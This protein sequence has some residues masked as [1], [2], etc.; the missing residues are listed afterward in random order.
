VA[1]KLASAP[2]RPAASAARPPAS[3]APAPAT[4]A[5]RASGDDPG[6]G[7]KAASSPD[8]SGLKEAF[9]SAIQQQRP[10]V[11]G[12]NVAQAQRIDVVGD[13]I[14]FR[15]GPVQTLLGDQVSQLK[16]WLEGLASEIAGRRITVAADVAKGEAGA[17][18][19]RAS[20]KPAAEPARD[21]KAEAM[22]D[23]VL[24]SLLD[25]IP[26]EVKDITELKKP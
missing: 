22:K 23:P 6:P 2:S 14:T 7:P 19:A 25:V 4:P 3:N 18:P 12:T 21:L 11:Y 20:G 13:R 26:A 8:D 16:G 5:A 9:L 1:R 15:Y 17:R 24:Q 10:W